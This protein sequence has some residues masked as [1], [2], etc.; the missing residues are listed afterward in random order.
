[1]GALRF[2]T[3]ILFRNPAFLILS[4]ALLAFCQL[5]APTSADPYA[6]ITVNGMKPLMTASPMLVCIAVLLGIFLFPIYVLFLGAMYRRERRPEMSRLY[7]S[8]AIS[9]PPGSFVLMLGKMLA[10]VIVCIAHGTLALVLCSISIR[11]RTGLWPDGSAVLCFVSTLV[12]VFLLIT[13]SASTLGVLFPNAKAQVFA[14]VCVWLALLMSVLL[15][16]APDLFGVRFIGANIASGSAPASLSIGFLKGQVPIALW[17]ALHYT[18]SYLDSR[19]RL[20]LLLIIAGLLFAV[21]LGSALRPL[22]LLSSRFEDPPF[23]PG[24]WSATVSDLNTIPRRLVDAPLASWRSVQLVSLRLVRA[25]PFSKALILATVLAGLLF[26]R[27][28]IVVPIGLLIP[29]ALLRGQQQRGQRALKMI[30]HTT[31]SLWRPTPSVVKSIAFA[32]LTAVP[33]FALLGRRPVP[34]LALVQFTAAVIALC[35]WLTLVGE[36][37]ESETFASAGYILVWYCMGC[38]QLPKALDIFALGSASLRLLFVNT[39]VA[40]VIYALLARADRTTA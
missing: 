33:T 19:Y 29:L 25:T 10:S 16:R 5:L 36:N 23:S 38:N 27:M 31:P 12:P 13:L 20:T 22:M 1:M 30:E 37:F 4:V 8:S 3:L 40:V 34:A 26:G 21:L 6:V 18:H 11:L 15:G 28:R 17:T 7:L 35:G 9:L 24:A 2:D 39:I 14:T 32:L